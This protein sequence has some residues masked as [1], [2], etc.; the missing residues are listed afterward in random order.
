[1]MA[2]GAHSGPYRSG[3]DKHQLFASAP[4]LG[5]LGHELLELGQ[6]GFLAAVGQNTGSELHN[7]ARDVFE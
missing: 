3:G 4:L 6:I 5:H 1:M 2:E 7:D